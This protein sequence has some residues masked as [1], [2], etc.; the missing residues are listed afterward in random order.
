MENNNVLIAGIGNTIR[1]DDGLG[2][3]LVRRLRETLPEK[4]TFREIG[5]AGLEFIEEIAGYKRV[6]IIDVIQTGNGKPGEVYKL[7]LAQFRLTGNLSTTHVLNL[8][9]AL[10]LGNKLFNRKIPPIEILAVEVLKVNEFSETLSAE[11][12]KEFDNTLDI[13][14]Q[15]II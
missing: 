2:I 3:Y 8:H 12:E 6:I 11:I 5:N 1:G 9:Q 10:M 13:I 14:K 7:S 4:Y 15:Y